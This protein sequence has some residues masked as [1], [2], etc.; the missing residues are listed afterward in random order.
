MTAISFNNA[1]GV[2]EHALG[3]RAKRAEVLANNLVN[4]DTPNFKARDFNFGDALRAARA[5]RSGGAQLQRTHAKHF[6]TAVGVVDEASLQF[7]V[8]MQTSIDGNTVDPDI[9]SAAFTQNALDFAASFRL[10]N[11]R[12]SGLS[13]AISGE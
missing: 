10:L 1:L 12:F 5:G 6:S 9:E 8:P 3:L 11:S 4:A 13:K 7:R 2:H